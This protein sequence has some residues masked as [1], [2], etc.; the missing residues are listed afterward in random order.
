MFT[1]SVLEM[2]LSEDNTTFTLQ[3]PKDGA[4]AYFGEGH[5]R[6]RPARELQR[7]LQEDPRGDGGGGKEC[8]QTNRNIAKNSGSQQSDRADHWEAG[9]HNQEDHGGELQIFSI[10][11][12]IFT[13][14]AQDTNTRITV[15]SV[16]DVNCF[17]PERVI[18]IKGEIP[19]ISRAESEVSTKLRAA[20]ESDLAVMTPHSL[21]FP[22]L[23]P[24]AM[25]S[26]A[27]ISSG[28]G[29]A[30]TAFTGHRGAGAGQSPGG[31]GG[32]VGGPGAFMPGA[33]ARPGMTPGGQSQETTYLYI[34]NTAVGA[35]IGKKHLSVAS[36]YPSTISGTKGS[37]IRNIIKFSGSSVKIASQEEEEA[38]AGGT[39]AAPL[40]A[41]SPG[42]EAAP[43]SVTAAIANQR[44]VTIVGGPEAQWKAQ[45]LIFQKLREE[46]F[47]TGGEDIRLTVEIL[48]PSAQVRV[49]YI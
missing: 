36:L 5:H 22:G 41:A 44:R 38:A 31:V 19:D 39:Q 16:N 47:S 9:R 2:I 43:T 42:S 33:G 49:L 46:G 20:Y 45:Y 6:V 29:P 3:L 11:I 28:P 13:L 30:N 8:W 18:T 32:A 26:T 12:F 4:L 40:E 25:M 1:G 15:S 34:P 7:S 35:I 14:F 24:A 48:V 37:H 27:G 21:M 23:P 10:S 17:N